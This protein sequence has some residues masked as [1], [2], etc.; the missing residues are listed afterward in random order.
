MN[1]THKSS[2][3]VGHDAI[4]VYEPRGRAGLDVEI[5]YSRA[6]GGTEAMVRA[7]PLLDD[8]ERLWYLQSSSCNFLSVILS[9]RYQHIH[10][11]SLCRVGDA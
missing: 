1:R 11:S 5:R 10:D 6:S 2:S 9:S 3:P 4:L 8:A 7:T